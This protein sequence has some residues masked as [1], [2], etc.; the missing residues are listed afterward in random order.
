M[1]EIKLVEEKSALYLPNVDRTHGDFISNEPD[2]VMI[3]IG[4]PKEPVEWS[5]MTLGDYK[6]ND[7][8][9]LK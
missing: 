6:C 3:N 2:M 1:A 5:E 8:F 4:H 9:Q 7:L